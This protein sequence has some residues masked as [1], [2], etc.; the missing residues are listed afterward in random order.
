MNTSDLQVMSPKRTRTGNDADML[1][2]SLDLAQNPQ[3]Q[4]EGLGIQQALMAQAGG[5]SSI[6]MPTA[7]GPSQ[8]FGPQGATIVAARE[9]IVQ[10]G[11]IFARERAYVEKHADDLQEVNQLQIQNERIQAEANFVFVEQNAKFRT[12]AQRFE[13]ES[14]KINEVEVAQ[15]RA[16]LNRML[17][18][19]KQETFCYLKSST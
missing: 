6:A 12:E 1:D 8:M 10:E 2:A 9:R 19:T 14:R 15:A 3:Q 16:S 17:L 4:N 13:Q 7:S 18:D 5:N 11:N